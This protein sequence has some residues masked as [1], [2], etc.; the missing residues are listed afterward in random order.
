MLALLPPM[1]LPSFKSPSDT[2]GKSPAS[3]IKKYVKINIMVKKKD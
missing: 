3:N 2:R 1:I